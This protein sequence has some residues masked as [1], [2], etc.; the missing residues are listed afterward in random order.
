MKNA[1]I[2]LIKYTTW[3]LKHQNC[4]VDELLKKGN[5]ATWERTSSG[6]LFVS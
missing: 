5:L 1:F 3:N 2:W 4:P 6:P